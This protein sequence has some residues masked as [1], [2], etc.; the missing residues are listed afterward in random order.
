MIN[1]F[2]QIKITDILPYYYASSSG[3]I[4]VLKEKEGNYGFQELKIIYPDK[5]F[6]LG[7]VTLGYIDK[8]CSEIVRRLTP[9]HILIAT[10]FL[11]NHE[12]GYKVYFLDGDMSN[13]A[14]DNL[15]WRIDRKRRD[16]LLN[17]IC[18][19]KRLMTADAIKLIELRDG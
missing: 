17:K 3:K 10:A 19:Q 11:G 15:E 16:K 6:R 12:I 5:K 8:N 13:T 1:R 14:V 2:A 18:W 7:Y 9:V 4:H